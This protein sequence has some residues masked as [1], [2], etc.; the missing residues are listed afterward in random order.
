VN[1]P[2]RLADLEAKNIANQQAQL[3][4]EQDFQA[5]QAAKLAAQA[6]QPHFQGQGLV[7]MGQAP[8]QSSMG[9]GSG[10]APGQQYAGGMGRGA[11][12]G[13]LGGMGR[14]GGQ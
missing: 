13:L 10:F 11:G 6:Q 3:Q 8:Q 1:E 9:R 7:G 2:G 12:Q 4:Y 14:G 5:A